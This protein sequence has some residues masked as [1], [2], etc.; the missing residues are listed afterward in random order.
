MIN[1]QEKILGSDWLIGIVVGIILLIIAQLGGLQALEQKAYD[2]GMR[3]LKRI[4]GEEV[5]VIAIDEHSLAQLGDWPWSRSMYAQ[6]IDL[7]APYTQA[8]GNTLPLTKAQHDPG[9]LYIDELLSF[10][11]HSKPLNALPE[12]FEQLQTLIEQIETLRLTTQKDKTIRQALNE[13]FR[14]SGLMTELPNALTMLEDKLQAARI[15]L[16]SDEKLADSIEQAHQVFLNLAFELGP[17]PPQV[18]RPQL[19]SY[20]FKHQLT[21]VQDRFE[22][23][24]NGA[25]LQQG[26]N[27]TPPLAPF[28]IAAAGLGHF[29]PQQADFNPRRLPLVVH[30]PDHY[31][32][33]LSLLLAAKSLHLNLDDIEVR[34]GQGVR[35]GGLRINTDA[36]LHLQPFFYHHPL[37]VDSF[38]EVLTGRIPASQ[39]KNKIVLFGI[40]APNYSVWHSTPIGPM[41]SVLVLAHTLTSLLNQ[42]FLVTPNWAWGLQIG[43]GLLVLAYICWVL[44][45]LTRTIAFIIS[46]LFMIS[47]V[48]LF[49]SLMH[50]RLSIALILPFLLVLLGHL[51]LLLKRGVVAYQ[52]AFRTHPD[53]VE[54][55]RLLGL[56]FQ[57]QGHLDMAFEKFR[58]CPADENILSLLYNLALDYELKRQFRRASAVYRYILH[59]DPFFRDAEQRLEYLRS[60]SRPRLRNRHDTL[61]EWL[62]DEG[63]EKPM[64]GRYQ[65]EKPLGKGAMGIVY[66]GRD[67]KLNRLVAIKTLALSQEF[68]VE[69]LEEATQ[70]F[71][72]E[73]AAAGRLTHP[74][75][76]SIYDAGEEQDLAYISM[77]YFKGGNLVP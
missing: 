69:E 49:I 33:A 40:T 70:R 67:A 50:Q 18:R 61:T 56:A 52:D 6:M 45:A 39:Y 64:L 72:R 47:L 75:I 21:A 9:L 5:V 3:Q 53:A 60:L 36:Q 62:A 77:E 66:L 31:F 76:I 23:Y 30:Y 26:L 1:I 57:G 14:T 12:Q 59:Y 34:L 68:D 19:P 41:P 35:L 74:H 10:F 17:L 32:P 65:I 13:F 2:W 51:S 71:F 16:D 43:L 55:N 8:M 11:A 63:R 28:S 44:P 42:D 29:N 58:L 38:A 25:P 27:V 73:A 54:S 4:P 37:R 22:G 48:V 24:A 7:L 20:L 15:E 46:L